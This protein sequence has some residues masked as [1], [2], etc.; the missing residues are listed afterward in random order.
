MVSSVDYQGQRDDALRV[1][2]DNIDTSVG[3]ELQRWLD[4]MLWLRLDQL[5]VIQ[6]DADRVIDLHRQCVLL[7]D[8]LSELVSRENWFEE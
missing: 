1:L 2:R 7:R 6:G 8:L 4:S 3:I 5:S